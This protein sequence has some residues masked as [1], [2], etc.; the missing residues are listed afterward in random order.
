M[1]SSPE[2][3][4]H[5]PVCSFFVA[6]FS[7]ALIGLSVPVSLRRVKIGDMIGDSPDQLLHR[8]IRA[9]GNF[10]EYVPLSLIGLVL[11]EIETASP[12]PALSIGIA[13]V[14][15]RVFHVIGM[16]GNYAP[17]RGFGMVLTYLS[18]VLT[19]LF[20]SGAMLGFM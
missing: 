5:L 17:L 8:R 15:G 13:L 10:I 1:E 9:Q 12:W 3:M 18:L 7:I 14:C 4:P 11:T 2:H 16:Y 6:I 20:L 19:A